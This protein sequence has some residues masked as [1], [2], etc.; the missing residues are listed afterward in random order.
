[1][2]F[3][4]PSKAA[5][6]KI[7]EGLFLAY[8]KKMDST[9]SQIY[10]ESLY[11]IPPY[12]LLAAVRKLINTK[13]F[14]P[15]VAEIREAAK[16]ISDFCQDKEPNWSIAWKSLTDAI[17]RVGRYGHPDFTD[18]YLI[19]FVHRFGWLNLCQMPDNNLLTLRAQF[20][21]DYTAIVQ[22]VTERQ[23]CQKAVEQLM[24]NGASME[25]KQKMQAL[26]QRLRLKPSPSM[27]KRRN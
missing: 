27:K 13:S 1:M 5:T 18:P 4:K 14:L 20:R 10:V 22:K 7:L 6:F 17:K 21:D 24:R 3:N 26:G 2:D 12:I 9:L 15:R 25:L 19:E 11:D 16:Q 8:E 23:Q